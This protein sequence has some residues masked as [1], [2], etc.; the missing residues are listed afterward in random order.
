M[1]Y[2]ILSKAKGKL[3]KLY[4]LTFLTLLYYDTEQLIFMLRWNCSPWLT[5]FSFR[6]RWCN[7]TD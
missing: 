3:L 5:L 7:K 4:S 2:K 6:A 1:A